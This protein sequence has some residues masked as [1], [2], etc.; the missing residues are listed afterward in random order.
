M[1]ITREQI[2]ALADGELSADEAARV[3]AA[4]ASDPAL[5]R[6][7][8]A[9]RRLREDL[10]AGLDPVLSEPVPEALM[11][12]LAGVAARETEAGTTEAPPRRPAEVHDLSEAR[13]RKE[14]AERAAAETR[15]ARGGRTISTN[16]RWGMALAASLVLGLMLGTQLRTHG[17]TAGDVTSEGGALVASGALAQGLERQLASTQDD[18]GL[19]IL[20]S[21]RRQG[22]DFCRVF[23]N[24]ATAGIACKQGGGWRLERTM[25]GGGAASAEYRQAGSADAELMAAA[26]DMAVGEPLDADQEKVAKAISWQR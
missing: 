6:Q 13:A 16:S 14:A 8:A 4:V 1:N 21:F 19:R 5:A 23:D 11:A 3:E 2:A 7:L 25:T 26:Q 18:R 20:T 9:E 12:L 15:A 22:G 24:G 17:P 10:R